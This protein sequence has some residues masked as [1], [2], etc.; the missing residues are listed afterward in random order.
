MLNVLL[1]SGPLLLPSVFLRGGVGLSTSLMI[2]FAIIS[3]IGFE[4][5]ME[6]ISNCNA[7]DILKLK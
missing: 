6:A 5:K 7:I 4:L 1:G 3:Y 2:I